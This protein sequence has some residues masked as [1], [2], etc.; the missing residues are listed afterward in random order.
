MN[1]SRSS[2]SVNN[3]LLPRLALSE[4]IVFIVLAAVIAAANIYTTLLIGWGDGGSIVAVLGAVLMLGWM[5]RTRPSVYT[6]NLGQTLVSAGGSIGFAVASYAAVYIAEPEFNPSSTRLVLMFICMG[7][8]GTIVGTSVRRQMVSY[9]FPSGTACAVIQRAVTKELAPGERNRPV[10]L[11]KLWGGIAGLLTIPTKITMTAGG[12]PL[13]GNL[14]LWPSKGIGLGVDPLFYGIGIVVGPKVGAGMLLGALSVPFWI[15]P[16]LASSPDASVGD[17]VKW[18]AIALLTLP[19]FATIIFAYFFRTAPVVP[20]GFTPGATTYNAPAGKSLLQGT[21]GILAAVGIAITANLVFDLPLFVTIVTI[22]IA[23]PLCVVNGRVTG[24]TDINPVRLLAIVLLSG[25]FW[26]VDG[27]VTTLLGMAVI[28]GTLA[29]VAVDMMQDYRTGYLLDQDSNH[30]TVV[31][32]VGV[33]AGSLAAI[34]TLN[35]LIGKLGIGEG[36]ALA[37]PGA[38]IWASMADAMRSGFSP[39][40]SLLLAIGIIS[41]VGC[42]Y[43]YLTV[44]PKTAKWMPSLFGAGIGMLVGVEASAAIFV[45]GLIKSFVVGGYTNGKSGAEKAKAADDG[46]N[47]TMLAGASVFA[48]GAILSIVLVLLTTIFDV[49]DMDVFH[50]GH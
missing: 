30:Q 1:D 10:F 20:T 41:V 27:T 50:I 16:A 43:A 13:I 35:M 39:S 25:F 23:W 17:W 2:S 6:L 29:S 19:T 24:D 37:A 40:N 26:M 36:S 44:W 11:L 45:G 32:F 49:L 3:G 7:M 8:F 34:P 4:W 18:S 47:D 48:A 21:V 28:G 33:V 12:A 38:V 31:Q 14:S 46:G 9:F 5:G 22:A 42:G 15:Q